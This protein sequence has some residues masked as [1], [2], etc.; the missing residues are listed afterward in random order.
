MEKSGKFRLHYGR[1]RER[2]R[3]GKRKVGQEQHGRERETGEEIVLERECS[4]R[5]TRTMGEKEVAGS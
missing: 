1:V 4:L 3:E 2:E 5:V